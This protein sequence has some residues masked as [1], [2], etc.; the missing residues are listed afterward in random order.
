MGKFLY[1]PQLV[2]P[3]WPFHA[4]CFKFHVNAN[5]IDV[6]LL[7]LGGSFPNLYGVKAACASRLRRK[8][9]AQ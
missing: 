2:M 1:I 5:L 3:F 6:D 9:L 4:V 8:M 7:A